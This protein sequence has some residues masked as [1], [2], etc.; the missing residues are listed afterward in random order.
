MLCRQDGAAGAYAGL[1]SVD[2]AYA[3]SAYWQS[4]TPL[5]GCLAN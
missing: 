4:L 2:I 1:G 5:I 3:E